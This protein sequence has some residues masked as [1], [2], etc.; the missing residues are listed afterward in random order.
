MRAGPVTELGSDVENVAVR[1]D[2][3][4]RRWTPL[5]HIAYWRAGGDSA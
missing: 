5:A 3:W 2:P 1:I 4:W